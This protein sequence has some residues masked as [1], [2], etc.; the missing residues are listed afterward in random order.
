MREFAD[1][2]AEIAEH[3][4][5]GERRAYNA[6]FV[7][8]RRAGHEQ[9]FFDFDFVPW[10]PF[11][12][13]LQSVAISAKRVLIQIGNRQVFDNL[14]V[15]AFVTAVAQHGVHS[16]FAATVVA[17]S[18]AA[19][20]T[21][22]GIGADKDRT[23]MA[24]RPWDIHDDHCLADAI[25]RIDAAVEEDVRADLLAVVDTVPKLM[26]QLFGIIHALYMVLAIRLLHA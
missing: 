9:E 20:R 3:E 17:F 23:V 12:S 19:K 11:T 10:S 24:G 15:T 1:D 13:H 8:S 6:L 25:D 16:F 7:T 5:G 14:V 21:S 22:I 26:H 18:I 4:Q 2:V